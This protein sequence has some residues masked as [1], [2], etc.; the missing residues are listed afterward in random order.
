M[1]LKALWRFDCDPAGPK[2]NVHRYTGNRDEGPSSIMSM[3]V[4]YDGHLYLTVGGDIWWGKEKAWLQCIDTSGF[5]DITAKGM[6]WSYDL[7]MHCC[8]A[9]SIVDGL[10][11]VADCG[12]NIHCVD[13]KTG[14][15]Y[16]THQVKG[17]IWGSTL[18]AD[19]MV[20][21]GTRRSDF[22]ILSASKTKKVLSSIELDSPI[23]TTPTPANGVLYIAT[24]KK[25]Y[26]I[27]KTPQ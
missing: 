2:E 1:T 10:V 13:A 7:D 16:W 25:L 12:G 11:F 18:A 26:A 27:C 20:Y 23:N 22:L 6:V 4:F 24:M 21:A 14:E 19:G 17:E 3:P 5:G 15:P 9:P 8:S